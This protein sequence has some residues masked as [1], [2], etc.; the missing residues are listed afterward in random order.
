MGFIAAVVTE[1]PQPPASYKE[2]LHGIEGLSHITV[3]VHDCS[4]HH[5]AS[6]A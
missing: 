6:A 2:R 3:E 1:R 4:P 5:R